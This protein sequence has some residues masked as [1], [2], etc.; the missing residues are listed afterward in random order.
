MR[1]EHRAS[2]TPKSRIL[3]SGATVPAESDIQSTHE[4]VTNAD[5]L[6]GE[7]LPDSWEV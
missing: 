2:K 3:T 5:H 6:T 1:E 7:L 4:D